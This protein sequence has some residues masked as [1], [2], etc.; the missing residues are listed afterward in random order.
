[1]VDDVARS[2]LEKLE[3]CLR[4]LEQLKQL[5][6]EEF[7]SDWLSQGAALRNLQTAIEICLDLGSHMI[8][9]RGWQTP[10]SY[11]GVIKILSANGVLPDSFTETAEA[12]AKFRNVLVH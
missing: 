4:R 12:M 1:M 8:A 6:R 10:E 3:E 2:L 11:V 7:L 9:E 5:Q